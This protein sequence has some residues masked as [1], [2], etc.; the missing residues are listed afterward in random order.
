MWRGSVIDRSQ[1]YDFLDTSFSSA[2]KQIPAA[3]VPLF[4]MRRLL[5]KL[6]AFSQTKRAIQTIYDRLIYVDWN[7]A[8]PELRHEI[9]KYYSEKNRGLSQILEVRG[10]TDH[11][12]S[13]C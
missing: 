9:K 13:I 7:I 5:L 11:Y 8:P 6:V 10:V 3:H 1:P 4:L 12:I 2:F